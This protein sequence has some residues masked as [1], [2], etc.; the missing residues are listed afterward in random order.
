MTDAYTPALSSLIFTKEEVDAIAAAIATSSPWAVE[1]IHIKSAKDKLRD[2]HLLR[3]EETC[4]Y[5]RLGLHG[6]GYFMIDR[7]HVLPK[8]KAQYKLFCYEAWNLSVSCKRCNM[9]FKGEDDD[10]FTDASTDPNFHSAENYLI[11]HPNYDLWEDHLFRE[12]TGVNRK[13]LVKFM[14]VNDSEKGRYTY[15]YFELKH[16]EVDS[17]DR[18]QGIEKR[19][20]AN[21]GEAAMKTRA[22]AKATDQ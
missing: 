8:G 10:F 15:D 2:F 16:L 11:I 12:E 5:C 22:L 21:A 6:A 3:H 17:F 20:P 9:Q 1:N 19:V 7:E 18:A 4:C 13:K 14:V